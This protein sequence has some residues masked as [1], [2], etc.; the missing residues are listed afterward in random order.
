MYDFV[1]KDGS[2][3]DNLNE[4]IHESW[5]HM[6]DAKYQGI[7]L[8]VDCEETIFTCRSSKY[9]LAPLL[10]T[11]NWTLFFLAITSITDRLSWVSA[12]SDPKINGLSVLSYL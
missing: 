9:H 2:L 6:H 3:D 10:S 8:C 11:T 5:L 1:D 4:E 12:L 7:K